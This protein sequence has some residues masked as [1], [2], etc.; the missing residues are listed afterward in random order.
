MY[1]RTHESDF[2]SL[3]DIFHINGSAIIQVS[4]SLYHFPDLCSMKVT[5]KWL[6]KCLTKQIWGLTCPWVTLNSHA[7]TQT[8]VMKSTSSPC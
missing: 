2:K 1:M 6:S 5:C 4:V 8:C 3:V 7:V